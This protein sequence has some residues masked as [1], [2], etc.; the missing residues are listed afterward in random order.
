MAK[1]KEVTLTVTATSPSSASTAI[2]TSTFKS[3]MLTSA[4]RLVVDARLQGATG[5]VLDV[6]LQRKLA[7]DT[8]ADWIH[9]PQLTAAAAA[10]G[11]TVS[12]DGGGNSIVARGQG[13]DA[14]PGVALAANTAVNVMPGGD[15]RI[16]FVA[17]ASTSAGASQTVTI[18]AYTELH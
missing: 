2:A 17:G 8:W 3:A 5:G 15:V 18:I 12:I 9:F 10:T 16:V 14:S 13:T 6:Y 4:D 1:T 7:N 11:Y